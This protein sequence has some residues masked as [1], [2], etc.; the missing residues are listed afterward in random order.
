MYKYNDLIGKDVLVTGASGDIGQAICAKF[1]EQDCRVYALYKSNVSELETLKSSHERG[2]NLHL[3][4]CDLADSDAV[5]GLCRFL[6]EKVKK[7]DVLINNA[8]IVRDSLFAS[9][10]VEDFTTVIDT[11][12]I[13]TFKLTK[14]LLMLLRSSDSAAIV[15]V[16]SIAAIIPSVGQSNYSASKGALLGFT[17]TLAAE[18]APRGVRVN[19]VAPGMIESRMVKK[20]SRTVVRDVLSSIP[21]KRLGKCD[22]VANAIVYLSS[23]ASSYIIGQTIVIDGGLVMR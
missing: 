6:T 15:N 17:R 3:L 4:Q 10:S 16:A 13:G 18:L 1:L 19:A 8:G 12:L 7:L 5:A 9:M 11:N 20:V 2:S 23:S 14:E 22:E 21:L